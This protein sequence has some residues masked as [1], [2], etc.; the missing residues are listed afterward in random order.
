MIEFQPADIVTDF[1]RTGLSLPGGVE[2]PGLLPGAFPVGRADGLGVTGIFTPSIRCQMDFLFVPVIVPQGIPP[3]LIP[4][5]FQPF[6]AGFG[7]HW[8]GS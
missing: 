2:T 3:N 7:F 5:V 6:R 4:V 1:A 8:H